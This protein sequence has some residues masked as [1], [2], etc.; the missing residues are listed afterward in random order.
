[1]KRALRWLLAAPLLALSPALLGA[2]E[3]PAELR[4]P[5]EVHGIRLAD[6]DGDGLADVLVA[7]GHRIFVFG[8]R[9]GAL[10]AAQASATV[11]LPGGATFVDVARRRPGSPP[12][13]LAFGTAGAQR[14]PLS[15]EAT[16][17]AVAGGEPLAWHDAQNATFAK[18]VRGDGVLLPEAGG[19]EYRHAKGAVR[20]AMEPKRDVKA[21]GPF[22]EDTCVVTIAL[23]D[24]FVGTPADAGAPAG[25]AAL[26][27]IA[28][29][30]LHARS[31][32][33]A[34]RYDLSFLTDASGTSDFDQRL[35]DLDG[36]GRP[37]LIHRLYTN[38]S[39]RYG[40]FRTKPLA[41]DGSAPSHKPAVSDILLDGYHLSPAL[42][43]LDGDGY[44]DLVVSTIQIDAANTLRA[45]S[46]GAVTAETRAFL[47][48][49]KRGG[50][51]Y[52]A[53]KAD[54]VIKSTIG[55]K[56][57]FNYAGTIEVT[58]SFTILLD[59]D[60]DGDGRKDLAIRT[61]DT[62]M[63]IRR[64]TAD[65]VWE[66][67]GREVAIPPVG[68]HPDVD[69]YTADL[70]GD[71]RD[72]IVLHYRKPPGGADLLVAVDADP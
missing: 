28:G 22:L 51:V 61:S 53:D 11:V 23:P 57:Q 38:R 69:G 35:E 5:G 21:P 67:E 46:S 33:G 52:F 41:A 10:P 7:Q 15:G 27:S 68:G 49:W 39:G 42:V 45:L 48:R 14:V 17:Q 66:A 9:R 47:N 24:V 70:D 50:G 64:G 1:M 43:D 13:L 20:L 71:G 72:E 62:A 37:E 55:V 26:W 6:A 18:L 3:E 60:Y 8:G 31:A 56:I 44:K 12:A 65:G 63:T 34:A 29:T 40:I 59:G 25:T 2:A 54:A 19:W 58:R 32:A 16:P 4:V 30:E 36:D